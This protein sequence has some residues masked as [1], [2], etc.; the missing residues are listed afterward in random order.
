MR[1]RGRRGNN[2][3]SIH[4]RS[5]G[6]WQAIISLEGGE[7]KYFYGR[8]RAEVAKRL[9]QAQHEVSSGLPMLHERQTVAQYLE[10]WIVTVKLQIRASTWRRYSDF[11]R[12]HLVPGLGRIPLAKLTAQHVQLFYARK[13]GEGLSHSTVHHIHGVLHRALK[14]ALLMGLVQRNV[15]DMVRAPRRSNREMATLSDSQAKQFLAA[16]REDR[17]AALYILALTTGMRKGELLG[18]R[19]QDLDLDRATL[20]VR[21]NVQEADGKFI[22]AETKTAYSRRSIALTKKAVAALRQHNAKQDED[23]VALGDAWNTK[24]DLV[25]PNRL[26]GIMIPD[27]LAKRSFKRALGKIGLP[28]DVRFHDLR[29]TAA[30]LLLSRGVHPKVVSEMLGHADISITLRVYA[31]VTPHMQQAAVQVMDALFD[32]DY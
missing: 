8:T 10:T 15:S 13:L 7:R 31:H 25:F 20:Q 24:L 9:S 2:E 18:L 23:R 19:W 6:R 12:V 16:V 30:T 1:G 28:L 22:V 32:E 14:D 3:R 17:L 29:H 11:V 27:N 21:M 26:G 5:D 4:R